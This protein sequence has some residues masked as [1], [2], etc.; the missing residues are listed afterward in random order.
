MA[1]NYLGRSEPAEEEEQVAD[2][3]SLVGQVAKSSA[4]LAEDRPPTGWARYRI[5]V[6]IGIQ[7]REVG[8]RDRLGRLAPLCPEV[9]DEVGHG[10]FVAPNGLVGGG[11][12]PVRDRQ[13]DHAAV[14]QHRTWDAAVFG[15]ES[16][17]A[18]YDPHGLYIMFSA[19]VHFWETAELL[20]V[21]HYPW[22]LV[23]VGNC[24]SPL[25]T[26]EGWLLLTHGVGP[27]RTYSIG[28][29]LLDL[30]DPLKVIWNKNKRPIAFACW[31]CIMRVLEECRRVRSWP[32]SEIFG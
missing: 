23:Q 12:V 16:L 7:M 22:G 2:S 11:G 9:D 10:Q 3:D 13:R 8:S 15:V 5:G 31:R 4:R 25:E 21:P 24:G 29:M 18:E 17:A 28:A 6:Q 32:A 26:P 27:M 14:G 20:Q 19:P 30:N 1:G